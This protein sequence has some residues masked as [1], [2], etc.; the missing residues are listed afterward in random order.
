M[1]T[2]GEI[3]KTARLRKRLKRSEIAKATKINAKYIKA[4]ESNDFS[5]LPEAAFVKGFIRNYS[6]AVNLDPDQALAVF[7]RDYDQ[8]VKGQ[9]VPRG[10]AVSEIEKRILW[11]PKTTLI[12]GLLFLA[13]TLASYF[14]YQY[15]LLAAAPALE[16][17]SPQEQEQVQPNL[18]LIGTTDPQA[19]V[20][21]NNQ[22]V[23]VNPD[24][25]FSQSLVLPEGE[26]TITI[27]AISR[28]GNS[29]IIQ[30]T[31]HVSQ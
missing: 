15:R 9:I 28:T 13:L 1:K 25:T 8:D 12:A 21:I 2:V 3:L 30:R 7:R 19:T 17:K 31:V 27:E 22:Q 5:S 14:I 18:M 24:G 23:S 11:T 4:L 20:T 6:N 10:L 29:R 26:R 16:I